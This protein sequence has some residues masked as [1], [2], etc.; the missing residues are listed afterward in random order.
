VQFTAARSRSKWP[1]DARIIFMHPRAAHR[2][3]LALVFF[4]HIRFGTHCQIFP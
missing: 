1:Q 4:L 3:G 2:C